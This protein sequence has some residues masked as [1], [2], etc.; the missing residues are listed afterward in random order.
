MCTAAVQ[1]VDVARVEAK[2]NLSRTEKFRELNRVLKDIADMS[3]DSDL[4][5]TLSVCTTTWNRSDFELLDLHIGDAILNVPFLL[6]LQVMYLHKS[7]F[8]RCHLVSL[9]Q[10][11]ILASS[12]YQMKQLCTRVYHIN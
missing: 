7:S 2:K 1:H 3:A 12:P 6:I 11:V 10:Q 9:C 8:H 4:F 5:V